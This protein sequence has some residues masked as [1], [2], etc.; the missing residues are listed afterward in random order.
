[1]EAN[2]EVVSLE[3]RKAEHRVILKLI[4]AKS[5][6]SDQHIVCHGRRVVIIG[7]ALLSLCVVSGTLPA[8]A[9]NEKAEGEPKRPALQ[10]GSALRFNEDWSVLTRISHRLEKIKAALRGIKVVSA[11]SYAQGEERPY[12]N[13]VYNR[14]N[15]ISATGASCS[16]R[17][18]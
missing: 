8:W 6:R 12:G 2:C 18:I 14:T 1:M 13:R 16:D 17:K 4:N 9:Q 7:L 5:C 11:N 3:P 15:G 10:I